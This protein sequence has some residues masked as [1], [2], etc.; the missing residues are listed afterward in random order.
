MLAAER[1]DLARDAVDAFAR[2]PSF[3]RSAPSPS[4]RSPRSSAG[5]CR[6]ACARASPSPRG[7][8]AVPIASTTA[9]TT[10][11]AAQPGRTL[12]LDQREHHRGEQELRASRARRPRRRR[13]RSPSGSPCGCLPSAPSSRARSPSS[14]GARSPSARAPSRGPSSEAAAQRDASGR[15]RLAARPPRSTGHAR[16]CALRRRVRRDD[17]RRATSWPRRAGGAKAVRRSPHCRTRSLDASA[18]DRSLDRPLRG[19]PLPAAR[20][21][22]RRDRPASPPAEHLAGLE[23]EPLR[24]PASARRARPPASAAASTPSGAP[25]RGASTRR[26]WSCGGRSG[27]SRRAPCRR[28]APSSSAPRR[29]PGAP[30]RAAAPRRGRTASSRRTSTGARAARRAAAPSSRRSSGSARGRGAPSSPRTRSATSQHSTRPAGGPGSRSNTSAVGR[31]MLRARAR[32]SVCS[33]RSA[34]LAT[35]TSDG[36]VVDDAVVDV[37]LVALAP[38][39]LASGPR[40]AGAAGSASR[41]RTGPSTPS[42]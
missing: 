3:T 4:G 21:P 25:A 16:P 42:G 29:G 11:A 28:G 31:S 27:S 17:V 6:A 14:R 33:S 32:A 1:V 9:A 12:A 39:R 8:A 18:G 40:P 22:A 15:R 36:E 30:A 13:A 35:Q 41:R 24:R 26:P 37:L 10:S 38:D 19:E 7:P 5:S 20:A 34:M 23:H 2:S